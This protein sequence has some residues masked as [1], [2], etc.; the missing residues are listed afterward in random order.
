MINPTEALANGL[1]LHREGRITEA[2]VFYRQALDAEPDNSDTQ[3]LLGVIAFDSDR[4]EEAGKLIGDSTHNKPNNPDAYVYL[5]HLSKQGGDMNLAEI[6]YRRAVELAP[7]YPLALNNLGNA[8]RENKRIDESLAVYRRAV[9]A[10]PTYVSALTNLGNLYFDEGNHEDGERL[11]RQALGHAPNDAGIITYLA[12]VVMRQG[13]D[14]EAIRIYADALRIDPRNPDANARMAQIKVT[15]GNPVEALTYCETAIEVDPAHTLGLSLLAHVS[16]ETG[17]EERARYL[18]DGDRLVQTVDMKVPEE[19]DGLDAFNKGIAEHL[20]SHPTLRFE[21]P[22][23]VT[24]NCYQSGN[25]LADPKGPIAHL[26]EIIHSAIATYAESLPD[27]PNHPFLANRPSHW[28]LNVWGIV[29]DR[30]QGIVDSHIHPKGWLSGVCYIDL[31]SDIDSA[32]EA[33]A[34]WIEFGRVPLDFKS[35]VEPPI[36]LLK[37]QKGKVLLFPAYFY[38]RTLPYDSD[39]RRISIAFDVQ[40]GD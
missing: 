2:E 22:G 34:G 24:R 31:P 5:G 17:D 10:D 6:H 33:H 39:E 20:L 13:R 29:I 38:H 32:A 11:L 3:Y 4:F 28:R 18:L 12:R 27:D 15:D 40:A 23:R 7:D 21:P 8:L 35:T 30:P 14:E 9:E 1:A 36:T 19:F 25:L 26:E 37:P 16:S